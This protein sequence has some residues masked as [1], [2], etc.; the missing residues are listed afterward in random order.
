MTSEDIM[1]F[2]NGVNKSNLIKLGILGAAMYMLKNR[3]K[4]PAKI[5]NQNASDNQ[6]TANQEDDTPTAN[7]SQKMTPFT[8]GKQLAE[9]VLGR[10]A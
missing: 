9:K 3:N 7:D 1:Q 10:Q 5:T 4:S 6:Q 8:L 2:P